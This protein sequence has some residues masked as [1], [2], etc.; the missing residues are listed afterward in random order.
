MGF[1]FLVER[2]QWFGEMPAIIPRTHIT[3]KATPLIWFC[4]GRL[5]EGGGFSIKKGIKPNPSNER[6][7]EMT[8]KLDLRLRGVI[9]E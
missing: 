5:N 6:R 7:S 4:H 8:A 2:A 9:V 3:E 1:L